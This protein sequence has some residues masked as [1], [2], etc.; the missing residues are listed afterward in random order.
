MSF[1]LLQEDIE[2]YMLFAAAPVYLTLI[3]I[4]QSKHIKQISPK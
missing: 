4:L 2:T 1:S 3:G